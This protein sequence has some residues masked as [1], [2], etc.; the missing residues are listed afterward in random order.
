MNS[1]NNPMARIRCAE[2][3]LLLV[4]A[5]SAACGS[6][7]ADGAQDKPSDSNDAGS[8]S[9]DAGVYVKPPPSTPCSGRCSD[10]LS[11]RPKP[12]PRPRCPEF[13]PMPSDACNDE[14]LRCSYG[15][16]I[17]AL[18]RRYYDCVNGAWTAIQGEVPELCV[19]P[20]AAFCEAAAAR[21][22]S[23]QCT[24]EYY[25]PCDYGGLFCGCA[26]RGV[27]P[28]IGGL[29]YWGCVGP[30]E[31]PACPVNLPN[32]GEGCATQGLL[33][34]YGHAGSSPFS[35][36]NSVFCFEGEWEEMPF[37]RPF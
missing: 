20:P 1:K 34:T 23:E 29:G 4:C 26:S 11:L 12:L 27:G 32:F 17:L 30:P 25:M 7:A 14:G 21:A 9:E 15:N 31:N 18:C 28:L 3:L 13:E 22:N 6:T 37:S 24:V 10:D 35:D 36:F 5:S 19:E 2:L 8:R 16:R 33:C